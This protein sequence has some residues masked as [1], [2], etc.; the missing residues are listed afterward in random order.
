MNVYEDKC[1]FFKFSH[2]NDKII[3]THLVPAAHPTFEDKEFH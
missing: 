1:M 2:E 3:G